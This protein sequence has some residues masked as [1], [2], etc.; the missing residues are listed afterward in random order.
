MGQYILV[1]D[2]LKLPKN[3]VLGNPKGFGIDSKKKIL[4]EKSPSV[5]CHYFICVL[6]KRN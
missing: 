1:E 6:P 5:Y 3:L 4:Y 2:W